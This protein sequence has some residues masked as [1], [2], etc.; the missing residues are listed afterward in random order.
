[1]HAKTL[2]SIQEHYQKSKRVSHYDLRILDPSKRTLWSWA[3]PKRKFP[4][5]GEK[6]LAIRTM[7]H[8]VSYMYFEGR[9]KDADMVTLF[10]RGKCN[11][12]VYKD[13]LIILHL[14][15]DHING[16]FNFIK[17]HPSEN[18]WL[19]TKSKKEYFNESS[20]SRNVSI[21]E[22]KTS[23]R[24]FRSTKKIV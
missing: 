17:S 20:K 7:N 11:I 5:H 10:D 15:G 24:K 8:P 19:V 2:F 21:R 3:F 12:I 13:N 4:E 6:V 23:S 18:S 22:S 14:I 16:V 9:L 1:M